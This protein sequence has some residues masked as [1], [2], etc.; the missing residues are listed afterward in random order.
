MNNKIKSKLAALTTTTIWGVSFL[1]SKIALRYADPFLLLAWR[2]ALAFF[3]MN[4]LRLVL[5]IRFDF[6]GKPVGK[7]ILLGILEPVIYFLCESYGVMYSTATFSGV[8]I[9]LIP[10]AALVSG[11][12]FLRERPT[13]LQTFFSVMSVAGVILMSVGPGSGLATP[14]GAVLM[15]GA[16]V[17]AAAYML[18]ARSISGLFTPFERTYCMFALGF[19]FFFTGA[20]MHV[21]GSLTQ[22]A[23][24]LQH[25]PFLT[26]ILFLGVLASVVAFFCQN[27]YVTYLTIPEAVVF[28]N[29]TTVV[30]IIAGILILHDPFTVLTIPSALMIIAGV[31]GVQLTGRK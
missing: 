5:R 11:A 14:A 30:S 9:A 4:V 1:A 23:A 21:R 10:I 26:A 7:L 19:I 15:T 25:T 8:M 18:L 3:L 28:T 2:F 22:L 6:S 27:Y 13:V 29:L 16:V 24:P 31:V 17:S 12:I 20:L